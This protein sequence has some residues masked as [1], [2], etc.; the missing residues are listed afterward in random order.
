MT[1]F[2]AFE[3]WGERPALVFPGGRVITYGALARRMALL[4]QD[5]G[6]EKRLVAIEAANSEHA[7]VTY[8]AA[9]A[10]GHAVALIA[11]G[12]RDAMEEFVRDVRPDML[13]RTI[14]S[15]WRRETGEGGTPLHQI[16][17][18]CWR[19]RAAP[20]RAASCGFRRQARRPMR[21]RSPTIWNWRKTTAPR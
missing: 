17:H 15:R 12:D 11:P 13:F 21:V 18:C 10:G 2:H 19:P 3:A 6:R 5:M 16:S 9:L 20:A 4:R 7:I 1:F 8:L 14:D